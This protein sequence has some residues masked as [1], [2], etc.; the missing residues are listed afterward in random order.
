MSRLN[1]LITRKIKQL[2]V[3]FGEQQTLLYLLSFA[4]GLASA[5]AAVVMKN[6]IHYTHVLFT[7]GIMKGAGGILSLAYPLVGIFLTVMIVKYLVHDQ[8]LARDKPC[9]LCH[10][11]TQKLH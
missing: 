6:A 11:K 3:F 2:Q 1:S 9:A 5:V 4:V 8:Y 10:L 7:Q